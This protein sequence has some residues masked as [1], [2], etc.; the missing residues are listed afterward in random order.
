MPDRSSGCHPPAPCH[1]RIPFTPSCDVLIRSFRILGAHAI[2]QA[3]S[4]VT[5]RGSMRHAIVGGG[6]LKAAPALR[7][8]GLWGMVEWWISQCPVVYWKPLCT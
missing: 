1:R 8:R 7:W 6:G 4:L 2:L 5:Q 3:V